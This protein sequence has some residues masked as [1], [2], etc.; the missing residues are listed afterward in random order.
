MHSG[1]PKTLGILA[2]NDSNP[3]MSSCEAKDL[4]SSLS[5]EK[6]VLSLI[7]QGKGRG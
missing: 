6:S 5:A 7:V 2:L 1:E 4:L 3:K